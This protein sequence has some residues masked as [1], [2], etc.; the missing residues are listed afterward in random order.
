MFCP[1]CLSLQAIHNP[2]PQDELE[3]MQG[4]QY[5]GPKTPGS[6]TSSLKRPNATGR[7]PW[8]CER[9][10]VHSLGSVRSNDFMHNDSLTPTS[11]LSRAPLS[12]HHMLFWAQCQSQEERRTKATSYSSLFNLYF[13]HNVML[14]M[15]FP[16]GGTQYFWIIFLSKFHIL[17]VLYITACQGHWRE[18]KTWGGG[19]NILRKKPKEFPQLKEKNLQEKTQ[20]PWDYK[21]IN[22]LKF[23]E[24]HIY[25][26]KTNKLRNIIMLPSFL[27]AMCSGKL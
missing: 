14:H 10:S 21:V 18:K 3:D 17:T 6:G 9:A 11:W 12:T 25:K 15:A 20:T 23:K 24:S 26:K 22:L 4:R 19:G 8:V 5:T 7:M 1:S 16:N 2:D 13:I 27:A